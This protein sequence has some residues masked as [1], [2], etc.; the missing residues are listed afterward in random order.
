MFGLVTS[1]QQSFTSLY[2]YES[3]DSEYFLSHME[4]S[5][6]LQEAISQNTSLQVFLNYHCF[7]TAQGST[8]V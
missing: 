4:K 7:Q 8:N 3:V 6:S 1:K 5:G 2:I